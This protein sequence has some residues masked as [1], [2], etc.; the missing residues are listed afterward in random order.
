MRKTVI[1][2]IR[3]QVI[4]GLMGA[5]TVVMAKPLPESGF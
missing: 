4:K 3:S 2:L 1:D 5:F